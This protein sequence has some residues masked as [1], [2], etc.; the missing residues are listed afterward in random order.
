MRCTLSPCRRARA[1]SL[2]ELVIVVVILGVVATVAVPRFAGAVTGQRAEMAAMRVM[3]DLSLVEEMARSSS[4]GYTVAFDAPGL[5]YSVTDAGVDDPV[6]AV[7]LGLEPYRLTGLSAAFGASGVTSVSIDGWGR[8]QEYGVVKL[9]AG[10]AARAV[11]LGVEA[12]A[13]SEQVEVGEPIGKLLEGVAE[14][15][16]GV[17]GGV[18]GGLLGGL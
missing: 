2:V 14:T 11:V 9:T 4:R 12:R 8:W 16:G 13:T 5:S 6:G 17:V 10:G 15:V 3:T 18:T 1:F 7:S